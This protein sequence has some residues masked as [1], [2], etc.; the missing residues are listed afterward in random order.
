[1]PSWWARA[2]DG[3]WLP[4]I[5]IAAA[6]IAVLVAG[7][8]GSGG[9]PHAPPRFVAAYSGTLV[10]ANARDGRILRTLVTSGAGVDVAVSPDGE[11]VY[12]SGEDRTQDCADISRVS[13]RGDASPS[14]LAPGRAP[15][16]SPDGNRLAFGQ[17]AGGDLLVA[18]PEDALR[19]RSIAVRP[20][21][22]ALAFVTPVAWMNCSTVF[23]RADGPGEDE[24][25]YFTVDVDTRRVHEVVFRGNGEIT[26]VA[27]SPLRGKVTI[28]R[29]EGALDMLRVADAGT[30]AIGAPIVGV[31]HVVERLASGTG[32]VVL[33]AYATPRRSAASMFWDVQRATDK[34]AG[35]RLL[36]VEQAGR[37][38]G[39]AWVPTSDVTRRCGQ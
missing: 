35:A 26:A 31:P 8:L 22:D 15:V 19:A 9:S 1:M 34:R 5:A 10:V 25:R 37:A 11:N 7:R 14:V 16:P 24:R 17:C 29:S 28:S 39:L 2:R 23:V 18:S 36:R 32:P 38:P 20:A 27:G 33:L 30:G 13:L 4:A 21:A 6:A 12:F 3:W